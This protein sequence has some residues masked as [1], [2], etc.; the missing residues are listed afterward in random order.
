MGECLFLFRNNAS[1]SECSSGSDDDSSDSQSEVDEAD[2]NQNVENKK[3][4]SAA[5]YQIVSPTK[6]HRVS[7]CTNLSSIISS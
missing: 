4:L 2:R 3:P 6:K 5:E 7:A 1:G